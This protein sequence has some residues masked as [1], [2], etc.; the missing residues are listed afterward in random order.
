M[1]NE[2]LDYIKFNIDD[3]EDLE[4]ISCAAKP[5]YKISKSFDNSSLYKV[6][7]KIPVNQIDILVGE[8]DR[9]EDIKKRY[10][11]SIP[12]NDF[13]KR[14][15]D[16]FVE[17]S[18][19]ATIE[20]IKELENL[21]N[22]FEKQI[23]FFIKYDK[24]Y[25]WQIYYSEKDNR[26]F[27]LFPANEGEKEV[28][29]YL[30][31]QKLN[32][33]EKY[34]YV[35]ICKEEID[36]FFTENERISEVENYIWSF[37]KNWPKTFEV[38]DKEG[39]R[40]MYI[41][42]KTIIE[43]EFETKYKITIE[44]KEDSDEKYTLSKALFLIMSETKN[45][46]KFTP[47]IDNKGNLIF[48][49]I[50]KNISI[51]NLKE[52][53]TD[54]TA[55]QQNL[56]Y[57]NKMEKQ[58]VDKKIEKMKEIIE[59][60]NEIYA[61]QEKQIVDFMECRKSFFKKVRFFFKSSKKISTDNKNLIKQLEAEKEEEKNI[62]NENI[63]YEN[64]KISEVSNVFT[65]SD[66]IKTALEAKK[67]QTKL[68]NSL[69]DLE[70]LELK[71]KNMARKIENAEQYLDEIEKHRKSLMEFWK[72]TNKDNQNALYKGTEEVKEEKRKPKFRIDDDFE[73]LAVQ[74][75]SLERKK[76]SNEESDAIYVARFLLPGVNSVI[77][78]SN[79]YVL[80]EE[81]EELK[82]NLKKEDKIDIIFSG[83]AIG[84]DR[85]EKLNNKEHRETKKN[86]YSILRFNETTTLED[87]KE[88]MR[89]ISKL[90]S[91]AYQKIVSNYDMDIYYEKRNKGFIIGEINPY[92]LLRD[93]NVKKIY[94]M[95]TYNDEIHLI[96]FTNY[97]YY[98]NFNKTLPLGMDVET[99]VILKVGE[100]K[101][102]SSAKLNF[103]IEDDMFNVRVKS[104][105]LIVEEKRK[106][107]DEEK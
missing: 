101:K 46:Y 2:V 26:Y 59:R 53:I 15:K 13:I 36:N 55:V 30:I 3:K 77:T 97:I 31:E 24:N 66:L 57:N 47:G 18:K 86:I 14:R 39:N 7:K 74:V 20:K 79:T 64:L 98:N 22:L 4:K 44:S 58:R 32:N 92:E 16:L 91:E 90:V 33:N 49:F 43:S 75:D 23:P 73:N 93:D 78:R 51:D 12:L 82:N 69:A 100:N 81:Y 85:T 62:D 61:K 45:V 6:Y 35:P 27:M 106:Y 38:F 10:D 21:Q 41:T 87:F 52:L 103:L 67:E 50:Y 72:F 88:R 107:F 102:V 84:S 76:L 65:I 70:A 17:Y 40:K 54:E 83:M 56:K 5:E 8:N 34:I 71:Q 37:T 105:S 68:Q 19:E 99:K 60:Q 104:V 29:F 96:Y 25:L 94:K 63:E 28:L 1:S 11:E 42:G 80:D 9:T 95:R 89:E 48:F